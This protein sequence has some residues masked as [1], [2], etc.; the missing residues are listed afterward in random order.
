MEVKEILAQLR[1]HTGEFPRGAL[2][3]AIMRKDKIIPSLLE[4]LQRSVDDLR[5]TKEDERRMD[6]DTESPSPSLPL[7]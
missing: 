4:V 2:E 7:F 6:T 5:A 1:Y 3:S